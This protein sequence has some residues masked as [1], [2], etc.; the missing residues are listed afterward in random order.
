MQINLFRALYNN[1]IQMDIMY[2]S[3]PVKK[4]TH[5]LTANIWQ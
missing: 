5:E 3:E 4:A 2:R 1:Y